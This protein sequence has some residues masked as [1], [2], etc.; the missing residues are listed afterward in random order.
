[1]IAPWTIEASALGKA[2][3]R[4]VARSAPAS[5]RDLAVRLGEPVGDRVGVRE[6]QGARLGHRRAAGAAVQQPD[7]ELALERGDL[8]RDGGL[9]QRERLGRARERAAP[10]DLAE[11]EQA[12][13]IEHRRSLYDR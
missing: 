9:G 12:A 5:S 13:W 6:Q 3:I 8:L 7:A 4:S 1:M 11:R 10:G 2:P